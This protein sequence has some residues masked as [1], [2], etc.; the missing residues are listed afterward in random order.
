M[1]EVVPPHASLV[2]STRP[3]VTL[4]SVEY[5]AVHPITCFG[6]G[7]LP[8][9]CSLP[10]ASNL[11]VLRPKSFLNGPNKAVILHGSE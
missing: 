5:Q 3:K 2:P 11:P 8:S 4:R 10:R 9:G 7:C 6:G 1:G